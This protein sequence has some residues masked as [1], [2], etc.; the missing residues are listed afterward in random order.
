MT[1]IANTPIFPSK[2]RYYAT[3]TLMTDNGTTLNHPTTDSGDDAAK[4]DTTSR[5]SHA[6]M[7]AFLRSLRHPDW[8]PFGTNLW[9][10]TK[11]YYPKALDEFERGVRTK[12]PTLPV[13][14]IHGTWLNAYNTWSLLG[15]QL[16]QAGH[17]VFA[18]NYGRDSSAWAGR[19][20]AVHGSAPIREGQKEVA[21]FIDKVLEHT[22][23]PQV[24][25]VGHSQGVA[26]ARL[27]LSDSGGAN[28]EDTTRNKVR[29]VIGLGGSNHGTTLSGAVTV[30]T[31][32]MGKKRLH[33][34]TQKVLGGAAIDQMVGSEFMRHLNRNG[35]TVPGVD[36]LMICSRFDQIVTPWRTQQ[37]E[38]GPGATVKNLLIQTGNIKDFSDHLAILYSPGVLDLVTE[39]LDPGEPGS[40]RRNNPHIKAAVLPGLGRITLPRRRN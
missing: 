1:T 33:A 10:Q 16:Q 39:A 22:G 12:R 25:L 14:L 3:V 5:T 37:L 17:K 23:A 40:Y 21:E 18:V 36:Y 28:A 32:L 35:D 13:V 2:V 9:E 29:R 38:A 11:D 27:Y 15:P 24:D 26:Q 4:L 6:F 30:G 7:M 31:K 20:K 34:F 8:E 19:P